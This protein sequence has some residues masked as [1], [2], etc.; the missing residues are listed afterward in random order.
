MKLN[1]EQLEGKFCCIKIIR[2]L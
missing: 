1:K 2:L